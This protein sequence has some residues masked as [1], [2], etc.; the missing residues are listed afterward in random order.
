[1]S[2]AAGT[3]M[4]AE[5]LRAFVEAVEEAGIAPLGRNYFD[6]YREVREAVRAMAGDDGDGLTSERL[7]EK[8]DAD[9]LEYLETIVRNLD[10]FAEQGF[11]REGQV[12]PYLSARADADRLEPYVELIEPHL[13]G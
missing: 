7:S 13:A 2:E 11:Q 6:R 10:N 8:F 12:E 5:E 4:D 3:V 9:D 1:M